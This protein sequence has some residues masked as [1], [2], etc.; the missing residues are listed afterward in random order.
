MFDDLLGR[1]L[2]VRLGNRYH[3]TIVVGTLVDRPEHPNERSAFRNYEASVR[4]TVSNFDYIYLA[5]NLLDT[6]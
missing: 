3:R 2:W 4:T 5:P 1:P 6:L